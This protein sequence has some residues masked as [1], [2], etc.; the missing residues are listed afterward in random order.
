MRNFYLFKKPMKKYLKIG[1]K[2]FFLSNFLLLL[3]CNRAKIE[4]YE[5]ESTNIAD[6]NKVKSIKI[7][8]H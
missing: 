3:S 6:T 4:E 7:Q 2:I 1:L 5:K 8:T